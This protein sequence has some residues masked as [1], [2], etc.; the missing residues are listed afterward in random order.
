MKLLAKFAFFA[1]CLSLAVSAHAQ[2]PAPRQDADA[3][4]KTIEQFLRIQSAGLPGEI[5]ITV[6]PIDPHLFLASCPGPE[7]FL[8]N[9]NRAWGK[10]T[11]GVRC[12]EPTRWTV[13]IAAT[14][15][16]TGDYVAAVTPL[17][18]GQ[19]IGPHDVA[20]VHGDLTTL[21]PGVITDL[22]QAIGF[23]MSR[24]LPPGIPLRVDSLRSRQAI[25]QGQVVRLVSSGDG[26]S[27][28]AEGRA[29]SS[30]SEGQIIQAKTA[31]GQIVSGIAKLGGTLEVNY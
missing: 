9:G 10:T 31:A 18:Q 28:T 20:V 24:S 22:S 6:G 5:S 29:L 11:V 13:Y 1:L 23:T 15:H 3:I 14:V 27:V 19:V 12:T 4:R 17:A 16:M 7:V 21:P 26:F 25:Q 30:A 8:P 2:A